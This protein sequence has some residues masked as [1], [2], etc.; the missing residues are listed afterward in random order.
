[1]QQRG[2]CVR[3]AINRF[4]ARVGHTVREFEYGL[5]TSP[6]FG[7]RQ[8]ILTMLKTSDPTSQ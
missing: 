8:N 1:M 4:P 2:C 6:D 3:A 7:S 5:A